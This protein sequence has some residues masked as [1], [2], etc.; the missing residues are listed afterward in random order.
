M[1]PSPTY[2]EYLKTKDESD[3]NT[4]HVATSGFVKAGQIT[5]KKI[6]N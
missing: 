2:L 5:H 3:Q 6:A 1:D 4:F